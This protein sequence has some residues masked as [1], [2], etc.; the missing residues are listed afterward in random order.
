M[1]GAW[2]RIG[3]PD[4][5]SWVVVLLVSVQQISGSLTAPFTDISGRVGEFLFLRTTSILAMLA[6]LGIGKLLLLRFAKTAPRPWITL[7]V[8]ALTPVVGSI[9]INWLLILTGFTTEWA[10]G[11]RLAVAVPGI[12]TILVVSAILVTYSR[13]LAR[14]NAQ[15]ATTAREIDATR[16]SAAAQI[17]GRRLDLIREVREQ[18]ESA[19]STGTQGDARDTAQSLRS[20][21]DDVVRPLSY[22]LTSESGSLT[23]RTIEVADPSVAWSDV[24]SETLRRNPAHPIASTLWLGALLGMFLGTGFGARGVLATVALCVISFA[25]LSVTRLM[26]HLLPARM[27]AWQRAMV[28]S[29]AVFLIT[30]SSAPAMEALSGYRFTSYH[31]FTG[32]LILSFFMIWTVALVFGVIENLRDTFDELSEVVEIFK[33]ETIHLNNELRELQTTISLVLHGPIQE[34][35]SAS[36]HR[37]RASTDPQANRRLVEGLR[38]RIDTVLNE[39]HQPSRPTVNLSEE[40]SDLVE[41]WDEIMTIEIDM[42]PEIRSMVEHDRF[43]SAVLLELIRESCS[44]AVRHGEADR[45]WIRLSGDKRRAECVLEVLNDGRAL[46]SSPT[47]GLGSR[48]F[49]ERCLNWSRTQSGPLVRLEARIPIGQ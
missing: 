16:M 31:A 37:L 32:W 18:L 1:R 43:A 25:I 24:I 45:V 20:L 42:D 47:P 10:V 26:W 15:L 12:F 14:R 19:L 48:I 9:T 39:A 34:A 22:R 6:V 33:R 29:G 13:E 7:A 35:I 5:I 4:A 49:D 41:L 28:F 36:L 40:L 21:V 23:P 17:E 46:S 8:F 3:S 11:R 30:G 2:R 38:E 44:N 27:P